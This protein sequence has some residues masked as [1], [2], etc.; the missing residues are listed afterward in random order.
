MIRGPTNKKVE[1][2]VNHLERNLVWGNTMIVP[3]I[4]ISAIPSHQDR[5]PVQPATT[6]KITVSTSGIPKLIKQIANENLNCNIAV[7]LHSAIQKTRQII[8]PFSEKFPLDDLMES[9]KYWYRVTK[10]KI[11][12]TCNCRPFFQCGHSLTS[13]SCMRS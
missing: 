2:V 7:S 5:C 6:K 11:D 10:K 12:T 13:Q 3:I 4:D 1:L 8:M 9:L